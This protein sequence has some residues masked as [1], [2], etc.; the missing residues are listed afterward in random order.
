MWKSPFFTMPD[1]FKVDGFRTF[2]PT[3]EPYFEEG[4]IFMEKQKTRCID[5]D[6]AMAIVNYVERDCTYKKHIGNCE[7]L[8]RQDLFWGVTTPSLIRTKIWEMNRDDNTVSSTDLSAWISTQYTVKL[9]AG[10]NKH[11]RKIQ[12]LIKRTAKNHD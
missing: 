4:Y 12:H 8:A 7:L 6:V 5:F 10:G 3:V 9:L 11:L 2:T 1:A